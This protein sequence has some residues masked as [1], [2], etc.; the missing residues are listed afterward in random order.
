MKLPLRRVSSR[1]FFF[2][3]SFIVRHLQIWPYV[4]VLGRFILS[5]FFT[6]SATENVGNYVFLRPDWSWLWARY[7]HSGS[8]LRNIGRQEQWGCGKVMPRTLATELWSVAIIR[9]KRHFRK[10]NLPIFVQSLQKASRELLK[11]SS[12]ALSS[13][14]MPR[15]QI[16]SCTFCDKSLF[17]AYIR[18]RNS[19]YRQVLKALFCFYDKVRPGEPRRWFL[20]TFSLRAEPYVSL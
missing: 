19:S 14:E 2:F 12:R 9:R 5:F 17:F 15:N 18:R 8:I 11:I 6:Y 20:T 3:L 4:P 16:A 10:Q 13:I 7:R 1:V